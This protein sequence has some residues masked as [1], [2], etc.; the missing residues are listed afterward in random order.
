MWLIH[1]WGNKSLSDLNIQ[2]GI[3]VGGVIYSRVEA[4]SKGIDRT[5]AIIWHV[6]TVINSL[7]CKALW[8]CAAYLHVCR[9][10][11]KCMK[12]RAVYSAK[13]HAPFR[14]GR[15]VIFAGGTGN[16]YLQQI[17]PHLTGYGN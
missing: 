8:N 14:K 1:R 5:S 13:S 17:L 15:I 16:P 3:V 10:R 7:P 6:A 12:C 11:L 2:I 9:R 4:D